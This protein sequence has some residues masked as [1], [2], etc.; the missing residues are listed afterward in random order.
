M[1]RKL[2]RKRLQENWV[3]VVVDPIQ[4]SRRWAAVSTVEDLN[5]YNEMVE[6]CTNSGMSDNDYIHRFMKGPGVRDLHTKE[7]LFRDPK[8][9]SM[10][11]LKWKM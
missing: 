9:A 11:I 3:K 4:T 5:H 10:F 6:W 8:H 7:F 1:N 2:F